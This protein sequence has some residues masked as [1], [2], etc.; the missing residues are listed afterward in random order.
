MISV[1][2]D[3]TESVETMHPY[4]AGELLRLRRVNGSSRV[5]V[6][7][8]KPH[9]PW[10]LSCGMIVEILN[11]LD[12]DHEDHSK[13]ENDTSDDR[14]GDA[15]VDGNVGK[16]APQTAFLKMYDWRFS[17]QLRSDNGIEPWRE[18]FSR[19]YAEM[20][21]RGEVEGFVE[22][23]SDY[24]WREET[25]EDWDEGKNE[26]SIAHES[27]KMYR[28][29]KSVY[30][31]LG[32]I[33]GKMIPRFFGA[34]EMDVTPEGIALNEQQQRLLQVKGILL[35]Y[36]PGFS[37][38][39]LA[40]N[41]PPEA[42][43]GIVDQGIQIVYA[44]NDHEVLNR[45]VR[46]DNFIVRMIKSSDEVGAAEY[47]VVMIDFGQSRLRG[48]EETDFAWGRNKWTQDEEGAVGMLMRHRLRKVG[49]EITYKPSYRYVEFAEREG[50]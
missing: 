13:E 34:V 24:D 17:A 39:K 22:K 12:G 28:A 15:E 4:K 45:D 30:D 46:P 5:Q 9:Q 42:C 6:R 32:D 1:M 37:L 19:E 3:S 21:R 27:D 40:E 10:T 14:N 7:I 2:S 31:R 11:G 29:E 38:S 16:T 23:L 44:L 49:I 18:E 35:E 20:V 47:Q 8:K 26:A 50:E 33:Q 36:I 25:E 48:E 41:V 43:Q